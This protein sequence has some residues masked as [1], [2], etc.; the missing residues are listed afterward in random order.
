MPARERAGKNF[1]VAALVA[2]CCSLGVSVTSVAL[3]G[4]REGNQDVE[5]MKDILIVTGLYDENVPLARSFRQVEPRMVDLDTGEYIAEDAHDPTVADVIALRDDLAGIEKRERYVRVYLVRDLGNVAQIVLPVRGQAWSMLHAFVALDRDLVTVRGFMVYDHEETPG[6]GAEVDN[7]K[8]R[9]R[10]PG[11]RIYDT[12]GR[13]AL[14]VM[15]AGKATPGSAHEIDGLSGATLTT[16]GVRDMM[17]FWFGPGG[18][19]RYLDRL[20]ARGVDHD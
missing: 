11:K 15:K 8:W 2:V 16:E 9:A 6:L 7:P 1:L 14:H 20:R 12:D 13:V 18:Y 3:R 17:R 5:R 19:K 10:W 4:R